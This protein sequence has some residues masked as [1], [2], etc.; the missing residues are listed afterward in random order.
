[1][2]PTA[3][4]RKREAVAVRAENKIAATVARG[5][6]LICQI[7]FLEF[8]I[9]NFHMNIVPPLSDAFSSGITV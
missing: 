8:F 1:M 2:A 5:G 3:A 9:P 7:L 4:S 6:S